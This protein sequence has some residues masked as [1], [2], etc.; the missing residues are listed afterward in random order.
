MAAYR[1]EVYERR[2]L[3]LQQRFG[4]RIVCRE[5]GQIVAAGEKYARK[6]SRD[7]TAKNLAAATDLPVEECV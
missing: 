6:A 7:K 1:I 2:T 5:N 4:L 3:F